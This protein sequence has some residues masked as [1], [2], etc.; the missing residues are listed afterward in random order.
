MLESNK[1]RIYRDVDNFSLFFLFPLWIPVFSPRVTMVI[2]T[3][4]LA[5]R[6]RYLSA[7]IIK[8]R[9]KVYSVV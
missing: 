8:Q 5:Y 9:G 6:P 4:T 2:G 3:L 7:D 1:R